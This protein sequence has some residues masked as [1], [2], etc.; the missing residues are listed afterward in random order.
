VRQT[1]YT[2]TI[3]HQFEGQ[4]N[5]TKQRNPISMARSSKKMAEK[6]RHV[7]STYTI[8]TPARLNHIR[9]MPKKERKSIVFIGHN[10]T[11]ENRVVACMGLGQWQ[12]SISATKRANLSFPTKY[13]RNPSVRRSQKTR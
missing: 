1:L 6:N 13:Q 8:H 12:K 3:S 10:G 5:T 7:R 9:G 11:S 4:D 2:E